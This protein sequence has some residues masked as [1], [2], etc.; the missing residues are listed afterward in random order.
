MS[1]NINKSSKLKKTSASSFSVAE[2]TGVTSLVSA[3][4]LFFVEPFLAA[5]PLVLF[6]LLCFV[7]P[8]FPRFGF[9]LPLVSRGKP[10]MTGISLTFDDGPS[11]SSTPIL[12]KLLARHKLKAT[13]FV[14]GEKAAR[15]PELM[16][17]I[18]EQGHTI[19]NHS[20]NH[21]YFLMLRSQKVMQSDIH[22][23]QE[24]FKKSGV[25]PL[26]FRPPVG[27]TSPCLREVLT[28][29]GLIVVTYSCRAFD[30]G[31]RSIDNLSKK[32]L[33]ALKPGDIIM[34]HDLPAYHEAQSDHW[35]KELANLLETLAKD[36]DI[37]PLEQLIQ[38]PVN[39]ALK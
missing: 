17:K 14:V 37:V 32:I 11:P 36:Y 2:K 8:F 25:L 12:L 16:T 38:R 26:I 39:I 22:K 30:R 23:T 9:Y 33:N 27:I 1:R 5:I 21:D 29:E 28:R 3:F 19:G 4:L 7:A 20:W 18:L 31:N 24:I 34:L 15:Y 6:L 13:F 35:Q 10:G